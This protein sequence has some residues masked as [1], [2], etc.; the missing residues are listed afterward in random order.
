LGG[1]ISF[2]TATDEHTKI[3]RKFYVPTQL[4]KPTKRHGFP[5]KVVQAAVKSNSQI[6]GYGQISTL[7]DPE[8]PERS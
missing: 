2:V 3:H 5:Y 1:R 7:P 6:N 4:E 8:T